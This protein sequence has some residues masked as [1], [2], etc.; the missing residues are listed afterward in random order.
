MSA[1][2]LQ[3]FTIPKVASCYILYMESKSC[4]HIICQSAEARVHMEQH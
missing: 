3:T 1:F 2:S 4:S